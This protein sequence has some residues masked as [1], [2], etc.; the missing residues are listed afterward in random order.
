MPA[1]IT[2]ARAEAGSPLTGMPSMPRRASSPSLLPT[3]H[4]SA[5]AAWLEGAAGDI[6]VSSRE[7]LTTFPRPKLTLATQ[8]PSSLEIAQTAELRPIA[9]L[10][11]A[12]G[13]LD[14]EVELYGRHKA[15]IDLSVLDRLAAQPDGKLIDV[16]AIT[17]T[18]AGEGKTTTSVA[19]AQGLG[20]IGRRSALCLRE[21]SLGPV[22]GI[23]GGA[24]GGGFAQVVPMEDMNLHFTGDIHAI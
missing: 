4:P 7:Y 11:A 24:A 10:A 5:P 13:L 1:P 17:P 21:A 14:E 9:D 8:I 20:A 16:T 22:F 18:K 23:K 2:T 15:K 19:L 6:H 3:S 12:A